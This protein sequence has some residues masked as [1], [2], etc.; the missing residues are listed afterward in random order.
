MHFIKSINTH[1]LGE[2]ATRK[3]IDPTYYSIS[4]GK[5]TGTLKINRFQYF[6]LRE[7][8]SFI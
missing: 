1:W 2:V 4:E 5:H 3:K 8:D 7:Y 6:F